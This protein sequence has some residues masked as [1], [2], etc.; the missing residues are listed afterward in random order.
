MSHKDVYRIDTGEVQS[1]LRSG[2]YQI[3]QRYRNV[4][5]SMVQDKSVVISVVEGRRVLLVVNP[6][7][8]R[9]RPFRGIIDIESKCII[10]APV[11]LLR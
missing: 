10:F 5:V 9:D 7:A 6:Y 4:I 1:S 2:C 11:F 8:Q 3:I